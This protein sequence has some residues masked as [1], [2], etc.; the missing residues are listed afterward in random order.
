MQKRKAV[1]RFAKDIKQYNLQGI[2]RICEF[3]LRFYLND[4]T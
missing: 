1:K 3:V 2:N 4:A